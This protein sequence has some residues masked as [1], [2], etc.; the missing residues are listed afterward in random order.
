[1]DKPT[2]IVQRRGTESDPNFAGY[3][4]GNSEPRGYGHIGFA[5]PDVEAACKRFEELGEPFDL[6]MFPPVF[7][8]SNLP[9]HNE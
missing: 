2:S 7:K 5:V 8:Y 3:H 1:M 6:T 4:N 9:I